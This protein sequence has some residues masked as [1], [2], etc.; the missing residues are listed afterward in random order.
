MLNKM[1]KI[2]VNE[3][4]QYPDISNA[5][6]FRH[7]F[8]CVLSQF[9]NALHFWKLAFEFEIQTSDQIVEISK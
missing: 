8:E 6:V 7:D 9:Q 2:F 5:N 1:V 3:R 4:Y